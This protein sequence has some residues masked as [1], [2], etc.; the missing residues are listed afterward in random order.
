MAAPA[1]LTILQ[2]EAMG[3]SSRLEVVLPERGGI[4]VSGTAVSLETD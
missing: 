1:R 2:G 4:R 3:Q